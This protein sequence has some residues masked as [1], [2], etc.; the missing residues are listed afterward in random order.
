MRVKGFVLTAA[1]TTIGACAAS[2]ITGVSRANDLTAKGSRVANALTAGTNERDVPF[3]YVGPNPC[4]GEGVIMDGTA[5]YVMHTTLNT[6]GLTPGFHMENHVQWRADGTDVAQTKRYSGLQETNEI[7]EVPDPTATTLTET[8]LH[9]N[10]AQRTDDFIMHLVAK[11]TFNAN[12]D[13]T[14]MF[15]KPTTRC[16]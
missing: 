4:N 12:G 1:L 2:D 13:P 14:A 10:G 15:D 16:K 7:I 6:T 3:T 5:H 9:I 8:D 11:I